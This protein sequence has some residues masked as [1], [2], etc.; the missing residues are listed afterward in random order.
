MMEKLSHSFGFVSNVFCVITLLLS[1]FSMQA[2]AQKPRKASVKPVKIVQADRDLEDVL[3]DSVC[4]IAF[5]SSSKVKCYRISTDKTSDNE[6]TIGG[7][8]VTKDCGAIN[9]NDAM[10]LQFLLSDARS[11]MTGLDLPSVP[12]LPEVAVE[13]VSKKNNVNFVFS[14][15]GGQ[16]TIVYNGK[17]IKT[18]KYTNERAVMLFFQ[19]LLNDKEW[20]DLLRV[21][22]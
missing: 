17:T 16:Y 19:R 1:S 15:A 2:C 4:T 20:A 11:Y 13:F 10:V 9:K 7:F 8:K 6:K 18:V 3:G 14:F 12:F 5:A 21:R 22:N